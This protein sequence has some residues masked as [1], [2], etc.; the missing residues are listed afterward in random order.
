MVTRSSISSFVALVV[1]WLLS[2]RLVRAVLLYG[3]RRGGMLADAITYRTLFSVF[4]GLLLGFS[5]AA[6]WIVGDPKALDALVSAVGAVIPGLVGEGGLVDP[7]DLLVPAALT[8]TGAISLVGLVGAAIGAIGSL[9]S[10]LRVLAGTL[11]D[12]VLWI[13]VLLRN[14][15]LALG[16]GAALVASAGVTVLATAGVEVVAGWF[17]RT[18][19]VALDVLVR[20]VT[21]VVVFALDAVIVAALFR[22]LSGLQPSPRDLWGGALLGALGLTVLQQL[23]GLFVSGAG[24]NPLLASFASLIA[25][26]LWLNLSTQV[27]LIASSYI[28]TAVED[29]ADRSRARA[30]TFAERRVAQAERSVSIAEAELEAARAGVEKERSAAP[31]KG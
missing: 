22:V 7:A 27:I 28:V 8:L 23:S 10:A 17:G 14:L 2:R 21:V 11:H 4:A 24:S 6:L 1:A 31:G 12:D 3:E 16:I 13:W 20:I 18:E 9:R 25:L 26:L 30:A 15:G 5:I 29:R 19:D